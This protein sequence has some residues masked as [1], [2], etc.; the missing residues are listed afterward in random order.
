MKNEEYLFIL[1][2]FQIYY[3]TLGTLMDFNTH[4]TI[5]LDMPYANLR[6]G[7]VISKVLETFRDHNIFS[8]TV[9]VANDTWYG[10]FEIPT[11]VGFSTPVSILL[12]GILKLRFEKYDV[13]PLTARAEN[14]F[15]EQFEHWSGI[16]S[17]VGA[18][19]KTIQKLTIDKLTCTICQ[20]EYNAGDDVYQL[21]S[22][23]HMFHDNC[24]KR[25]TIEQCKKCNATEI[26]SISYHAHTAPFMHVGETECPICQVN[27]PVRD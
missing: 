8:A 19:M 11:A 2:L 23:K 13:V 6:L 1:H 17:G 9:Q 14:S 16:Y 27:L 10:N 25:W 24:I 20:C 15:G 5:M 21:D 12:G 22:C 26:G 18:R 7:G 3:T 4:M